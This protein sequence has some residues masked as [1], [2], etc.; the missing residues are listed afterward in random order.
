MTGP[1]GRVIADGLGF[2]EGPTIMRDGTIA[3]TSL[4][5]ARVYAIRDGSVS[6]WDAAPD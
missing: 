5:H 1:A 3:V 6:V 4:T 2:T